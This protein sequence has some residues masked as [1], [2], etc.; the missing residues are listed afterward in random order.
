MKYAFC[1]IHDFYRPWWKAKRDTDGVHALYT[2]AYVTCSRTGRSLGRGKRAWRRSKIFVQ[3]LLWSF[4]CLFSALRNTMRYG[5][6][7]QEVCG[8]SLYKQFADQVTLGL[9]EAIPPRS[10]YLFSL[11]DEKRKALAPYF[12]HYH[13]NN[14]LAALFVTAPERQILDGKL[15]FHDFCKEHDF[16]TPPVLAHFRRGEQGERSFFPAAD[17]IIKPLAGFAGGRIERWEQDAGGSWSGPGGSELEENRLHQHLQEL[18]EQGALL[19]QPRLYNHGALEGLS[20]GGLCSARLV[21]VRA[22]G[23]QA[24]LVAAMLR[25]PRGDS[26]VDNFAAGGIACRVDSANGKLQ[27]PAVTWEPL[28]AG[29]DT[30]PDTGQVLDGLELPDWEEAVQ[31]CLR[32]HGV[33]D[34][35]PAIGWDVAFTPDGPVLVEG[36]LPFGIELTQ[37]VSEQPLLVGP[38]LRAHMRFEELRRKHADDR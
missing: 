22:P 19:V 6:R 36:N 32:A 30:H 4:I 20:L 12:V 8:K 38:F 35:C 17:L 18:A 3:S 26:V 2:R 23:E 29:Y 9:S 28:S 10:Y 34:S 21:T 7:A 31:I 24:V 25:M 13:E 11:F 5:R 1:P 27:G 15:R 33:L 16:P 37:F 14:Y